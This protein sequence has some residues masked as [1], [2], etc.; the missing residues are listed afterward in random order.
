MTVG[1]L[2]IL[3][4]A[5]LSLLQLIPDSPAI[6]Q[7]LLSGIPLTLAGGAMALFST[8]QPSILRTKSSPGTLTTLGI[9][10]LMGGVALVA[11][12][13]PLAF[14]S[15]QTETPSATPSLYLPNRVSQ[16][17]P[18]IKS[19]T[20]AAKGQQQVVGLPSSRSKQEE[21]TSV[22]QNALSALQS[23]QSQQAEMLLNQTSQLL[24]DEAKRSPS[25]REEMLQKAAAVQ[26]SL[27]DLQLEK[28]EA[29]KAILTYKEALKL[30]PKGD[31]PRRIE[32]LGKW[33]AAL[34]KRGR[35]VEAEAVLN[36]AVL[37]SQKSFAADSPQLAPPLRNLGA[38]YSGTGNLGAAKETLKEALKI[39]TPNLGSENPIVIQTKESIAAIEENQKLLAEEKTPEQPVTPPPPTQEVGEADLV[40]EKKTVEPD[41]PTENIAQPPVAMV[42]LIPPP[43]LTNKTVTLANKALQSGNFVLAEN[44]LSRH[45]EVKEVTAGKESLSTASALHNLASALA[46][47]G[48]FSQAE[49]L[50]NESIR[51]KNNHL[52]ASDPSL[53]SGY[54][55]LAALSRA[56][57]RYDQAI[58]YQNRA[59]AIEKAHVGDNH[60]KVAV[61]YNDLA[62][63]YERNRDYNQAKY[64]YEKSLFIL[65]QTPNP[66]NP[67]L[68]V[69]MANYASTLQHLNNPSAANSYLEKIKTIQSGT[70]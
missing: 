27:A 50:L 61:G 58:S 66:N 10:T 25:Q 13:W 52:D 2:A 53:V 36:R 43:T 12:L 62:R 30:L 39:D 56:Q 6:N 29:D 57:K 35:I 4:P 1:L 69:V 5:S 54:R 63:L 19:K 48:K 15:Q 20:D 68:A 7:I 11:A 22:H 26:T 42:T 38:F 65:Q 70:Q 31:I 59:L 55:H 37:L 16:Y 45:L 64:Y 28:A 33:G 32:L 14:S 23:G 17:N 51:I 60:P 40:A 9:P 46:N 67:Y 49:K 8:S 41:P 47:Q 44:L 24:L 3:L 34:E 21:I 18:V